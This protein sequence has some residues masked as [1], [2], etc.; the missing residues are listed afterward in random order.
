MQDFNGKTALV[1]GG[2]SGIGLAMVEAFLDAGMNA[3][4]ADIEA[5]A[6]EWARAGRSGDTT[7]PH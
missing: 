1:T 3:V 2:A 6:R 4:I 7:G 5:P